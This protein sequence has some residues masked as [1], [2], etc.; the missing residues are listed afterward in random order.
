[1]NG[2]ATGATTGIAGE[3][4]RLRHAEAADVPALVA[5]E[6]NF[7]G[8]R[9]SRA[10]LARLVAAPAASVWVA[11]LGGQVVGDAV[12]AYPPGSDAARVYSLAI[13]PGFR[14]RGIAASLMRRL[15][16]EAVERGCS[17]LRLEVRVD[18]VAARRLY[19]A[20]GYELVGTVEGF[21]HDRSSALLLRKLVGAAREAPGA[22]S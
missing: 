1:M 6:R 22:G 20:L 19:E 18:N 4:V 2:G 17:A 3:A 14:R 16:L 5:L 9:M 10:S 12:V 11:E 21:Y 8:D 15:E 13:E 7:S